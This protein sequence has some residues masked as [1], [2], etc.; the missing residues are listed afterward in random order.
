ML[1][2]EIEGECTTIVQ[3]SDFTG[4]KPHAVLLPLHGGWI[5]L[6]GSGTLKS[7]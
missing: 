1:A 5:A 3:F 6:A 4:Y 7:D 2:T